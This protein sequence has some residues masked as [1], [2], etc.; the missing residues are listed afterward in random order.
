VA[1]KKTLRFLIID[2]QLI[3]RSA[4][5]TIISSQDGYEVVG[6]AGNGEAG[7]EL[8]RRLTPQIV[9]LDLNMPHRS[10]MEV[11]ESLRTELPK[12][13]VVVIS[14]SND[15][16]TVQAAARLGAAGYIAKPFSAGKVL[17][18]LEL[19]AQDL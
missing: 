17:D 15:P 11:L 18:S 7:L 9:C 10:G 5:R 1:S 19:I 3:A 14:G 8:A 13:A 4:L 16:D 12:I 6:E 2:D